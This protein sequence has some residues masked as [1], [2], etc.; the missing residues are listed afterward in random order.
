MLR[1]MG[2]F[3][4]GWRQEQADGVSRFLRQAYRNLSPAVRGWLALLRDFYVD[5]DK[6]NARRRLRAG[7][8]PV[9]TQISQAA[10]LHKGERIFVDCG[11]NTGEVLQ[12]FI[13]FLPKDFK[14]YGFEI[15]EPLFAQAALGLLQRNSEIV[16]LQFQAVSDRDGE[17]E[18]FSSGTSHGLVIGEAT[19]IVH[20][21]LTDVRQY[22]RPQKARAID[23][24]NW[25]GQ[26]VRKHTSAIG[27]PPYVVIKMDIEGAECMVLEHMANMGTLNNINFLMIEFHSYLFE[28]NLR[29][30]YEMREERLRSILAD[31]GVQVIEWG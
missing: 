11:F 8:Q 17:A 27:W 26:I 24:S 20:G 23:F 18:F 30:E 2:C 6:P 25:V 3:G 4:L 16:S 29:R 7:I 13:D 14:Y 22:D 21:M 12:G 1:K 31:R 28:G 10:A 15:N 19:T 5:R 9:A